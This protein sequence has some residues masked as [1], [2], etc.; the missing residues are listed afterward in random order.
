MIGVACATVTGDTTAIEHVY[1]YYGETSLTRGTGVSDTKFNETLGDTEEFVPLAIAPFQSVNDTY[2]YMSW[3]SGISGNIEQMCTAH[4]AISKSNR[5]ETLFTTFT[6]SVGAHIYSDY[7]DDEPVTLFAGKTKINL[8][9][10]DYSEEIIDDST[11]ALFIEDTEDSNLDIK[12][13]ANAASTI[14]TSATLGVSGE[15]AQNFYTVYTS[16]TEMGQPDY[17]SLYFSID[18]PADFLKDGDIIYQWATVIPDG[19]TYGTDGVLS[20]S[21]QTTVGDA[22]A[23]KVREFAG[24]TKMDFA[25]QGTNAVNEQ[26]TGE[27][28]ENSSIM[29]REDEAFYALSD[30]ELSFKNKVQQ[31]LA[32]FPINKEDDNS[33]LWTTYEVRLGARRYTGKADTSPINLNESTID[34][35]VLEEPVYESTWDEFEELDYNEVEVEWVEADWITVDIDEATIS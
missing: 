7:K 17:L 35:M 16:T 24:T 8:S 12:P 20:F 21:C 5:D 23:V 14:D 13:L 29:K 10:P 2:S 19:A 30:S 25:T 22:A 18:L 27:V 9:E 4:M 32:M 6:M 3:D 26:N 15:A 34:E 1:N 33:S 11:A 31:C 28:D